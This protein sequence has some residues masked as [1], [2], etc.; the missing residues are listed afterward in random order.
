MAPAQTEVKKYFP[1]LLAAS[2]EVRTM[3]C[4]RAWA[5]TVLSLLPPAARAYAMH[6]ARV[7]ESRAVC[8]NGRSRLIRVAPTV[9]T[10]AWADE[11]APGHVLALEL[12]DA[13]GVPRRGP[14]TVSRAGAATLDV[15]YRVID[16]A[17]LPPTGAA[18]AHAAACAA[19][20]KSALLAATSAGDALALGGRFHTPIWEGIELRG[21]AAVFL[22]SSGVGVGPQLGFA[23]LCAASWRSAPSAAHAAPPVRLFAGFREAGDVA[24]AAELDELADASDVDPRSGLARFAWVACLSADGEAARPRAWRAETRTGRTSA[25]APPLIGAT[26]RALGAPLSACHFHVIGR[27][28]L[29]AEWRQALEAVGVAAGRVS[30]EVYF[31]HDEAADPTAVERIARALKNAN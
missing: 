20:R 5:V 27:G 1:A 12:R 3:A 29:V 21:C 6:G 31:A 28:G 17:Q 26:A 22:V 10:A 16:P 4:A 9:G 18:A 19:E 8:A 25:A 13:G 15:I 23:E 24:C 11:Y 7:V 2:S 30:S 14:Y